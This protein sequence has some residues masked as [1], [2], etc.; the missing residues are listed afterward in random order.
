MENKLGEIL[1][2]IYEN[3][4]EG[5][6]TL[7]IHLFGIKYGEQILNNNLRIENIVNISGIKPIYKMEI[8][9]GI[10]LSK[11]VVVK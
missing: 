11:Y 2:E 4:P 7:N 1:R 6:K 9:K 3:S 10:I 5:L 8:R